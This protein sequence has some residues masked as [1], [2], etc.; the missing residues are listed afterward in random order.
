MAE[1]D[2][3]IALP[4]RAAGEP[5]SEAAAHPPAAVRR[6]RPLSVVVFSGD[7][8]FR[9]VTSV[10]IA[11]RGSAIATTGEAEQLDP[12]VADV[13]ADVVVVDL[14]Y[15]PAGWRPAAGAH[16]MPGAPA[17]ITVA[18]AAAEGAVRPSRPRSGELPPL[19]K[20]GPFEGLYAAIEAADARRARLQEV[21]ART[22]RT[23][24]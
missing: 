20:W 15:A 16:G 21:S 23:S 2:N 12:L 22:T 5:H 13:R 6:I 1:H 10:L 4:P 19:E 7:Q 18:G 9:S 11:R 8:R 3:L 14:D 17:V 24:R